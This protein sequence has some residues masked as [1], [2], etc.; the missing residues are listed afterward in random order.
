[1]MRCNK[2]FQKVMIFPD[3][4]ISSLEEFFNNFI[5]FE[6]KFFLFRNPI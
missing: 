1:M 3:N 4:N 5:Y 2:S 6:R